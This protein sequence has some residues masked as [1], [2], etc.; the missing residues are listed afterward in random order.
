MANSS[1]QAALVQLEQAVLKDIS[2][3]GQ[4]SLDNFPQSQ[5]LETS[6]QGGMSRIR[7]LMRDLELLVEELD[8]YAGALN[9]ISE[10]IY[11]SLIPLANQ[12]P[13]VFT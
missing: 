11:V 12:T 7:A 8:R 9:T 6:I 4:C 13:H 1:E 5:K 10:C 3:Y 2:E